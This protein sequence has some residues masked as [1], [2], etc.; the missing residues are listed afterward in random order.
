TFLAKKGS[1]VHRD[2]PLLCFTVRYPAALTDEQ[3]EAFRKRAL[4]ALRNITKK[5]LG[6]NP[7]PGLARIYFTAQIYL[8]KALYE[9]KK[10]DELEKFV[11]Q[12]GKQFAALKDKDKIPEETRKELLSGL[13]Y[14]GKLAKVGQTEAKYRAGAYD[15]VL[16]A[17]EPLV[18][19][20][21]Q[22]VQQKELTYQDYRQVFKPA[23]AV[24][25]R[26]HVQKGN[27]EHAKQTLELMKRAAAVD[28][29]GRTAEVL[30]TIVHELN[31][32]V[33]ELEKK[34]D[35]Q[36]LEATVTKFVAFLD[37]LAKE[38]EKLNEEVAKLT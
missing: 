36:E 28:P 23:L 29:R 26:A 11:D 32:Q 27:L 9:E 14:L 2:E 25:L 37:E 34:G 10:Y 38:I 7:D 18:K 16:K 15:D 3:R 13:E 35:R 5:P 30:I 24:V 21:E 17:A 6:D 22:L 31:D 20:V 19:Q 1:T 4:A 33:K 8:G 12:T